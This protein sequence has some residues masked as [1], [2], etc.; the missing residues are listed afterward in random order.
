MKKNY[1]IYINPKT[2][3]L[4]ADSQA[5]D[6]YLKTG[7]FLKNKNS[8]MFNHKI[9]GASSNQIKKILKRLNSDMPQYVKDWNK[10]L[11]QKYGYNF[12]F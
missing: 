5:F 10:S 8:H 4:Y 11:Y 12:C 3:T 2:G 6:H 7:T 1:D 9:L